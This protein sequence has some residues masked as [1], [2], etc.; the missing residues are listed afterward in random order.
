PTSVLSPTQYTLVASNVAGSSAEASVTLKVTDWAQ[1][2]LPSSQN[3]NSVAYGNNVFVALAYGSSVAATSPDGITWTP[4]ALPSSQNW[5]SVA[6][7]NNVFVALAPGSSVAATS[8]DGIT[9]IQ[10]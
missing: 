2:M 1:H 7:G 10:Q 8:P 9:W 6:Y 4:R 3:W 5:N